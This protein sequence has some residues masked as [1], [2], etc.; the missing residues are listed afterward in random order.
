MVLFGMPVLKSYKRCVLLLFHMYIT[1]SNIKK[2]LGNSSWIINWIVL[3]IAA[4]SFGIY[5]GHFF[6]LLVSIFFIA[7]A[8][9]L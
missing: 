6:G 3:F 1:I 7:F 2:A 5:I 8:Y 4:I 9:K